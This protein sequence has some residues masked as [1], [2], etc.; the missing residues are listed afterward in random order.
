MSQNKQIIEKALIEAQYVYPEIRCLPQMYDRADK[1][2]SHPLNYVYTKED[3]VYMNQ[4]I[5][6]YY[7]NAVNAKIFIFSP[8]DKA[9]N[10]SIR[11]LNAETNSCI[12]GI[13]CSSIKPNSE[14]EST[15]L[16]NLNKTKQDSLLQIFEKEILPKIQSEIKTFKNEK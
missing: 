7:R 14:W 16:K 11:V 1:I 5:K 3:S 4:V 12:L 8:K 13:I 15:D 2:Y 10:Y 9:I 6:D